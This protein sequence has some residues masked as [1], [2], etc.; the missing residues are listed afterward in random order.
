LANV[1]NVFYI[2]RI[3]NDPTMRPLFLVFYILICT[4]VFS[5]SIG[6]KVKFVAVDQKQYTGII[7]EIQGNYYK[8]K[9]DNHDFEAWLLG[10]QFTIVTES[11]NQYSSQ[12]KS[13]NQ[14]QQLA[15]ILAYG[16]RMGWANSIMEATYANYMAKLSETDKVNLLHFLSQA[17]TLSARFFVLKSLLAGDDFTILQKFINELNAYPE[18]VQQE[19]CLITNHRS[20]IQQWQYSCSVTTVQTYLGDLSP[21]YAWDVKQI[22]NYDLVANVPA[23][24]MAQQQKLLLEQYGGVASPRGD[25]SGR[26]IGILEPLNQLVGPAVGARFYAQEVTESLPSL[27]SKIRG[28][29]D[30]SLLVPLLINFEGITGAHFIMVMRYRY[31]Q[32]SYQYL[33]YDPWEGV[34]DYVNEND[35]HNGS[36]TPINTKYKIRISYYYPTVPLTAYEINQLQESRKQKSF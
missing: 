1:K 32:G 27:F 3:Q 2:Y 19:K 21:R 25:E 36:L 6:S 29:L 13:D 16:K 12:T 35:L 14:Q 30:N 4:S 8:V 7:K 17:T 18:S 23:N 33:V 22:A 28:Q 34:C 31:S 24:S 9:Y 26:A 20:I 15:G 5:Q 10:T 11:S